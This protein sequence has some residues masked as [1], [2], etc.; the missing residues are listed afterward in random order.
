MWALTLALLAAAAGQTAAPVGE[1]SA[2][3]WAAP[4]RPVVLLAR[5]DPPPQPWLRGH[6]GVDLRVAPGDP[7]R[8]ARAGRVTF[9]ADLAGRG[10]VVVDHGDLRT[11]YE[12]VEATVAVGDH[13]GTREVIGTVATGTGHCGDGLCL[14]LG[15]RRDRDYLDPLLL[16]GPGTPRLRPW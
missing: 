3:G 5:F 7:V 8:A 6:R 10:V 4:V 14:H 16:L 12:P 2:D 11:T 13:V 15:L 1:R 9:A